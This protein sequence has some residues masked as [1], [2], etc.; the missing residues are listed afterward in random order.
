M[1]VFHIS[2]SPINQL[3]PIIGNEYIIFLENTVIGL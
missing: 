2:L 1:H 3:V